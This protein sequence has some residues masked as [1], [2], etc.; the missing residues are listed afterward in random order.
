MFG[1]RRRGLLLWLWRWRCE[2][3]GVGR[4]VHPG[5]VMPVGHLWRCEVAWVDV[6]HVIQVRVVVLVE[7]SRKCEFWVVAVCGYMDPVAVPRAPLPIHM[8]ET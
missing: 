2:G 5:Q 7:A 3:F 1:L 8:C 4:W 6:E